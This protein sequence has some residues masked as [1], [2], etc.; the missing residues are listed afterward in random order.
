MGSIEVPKIIGDFYEG[1]FG[2]SILLMLAVESGPLLLQEMLIDLA[3]ADEEV[4]LLKTEGVRLEH[5][6]GFVLRR[7]PHPCAKALRSIQEVENS[8]MWECTGEEWLRLAELIEPFVEGRSGHQYLTS[9]VRDDA[10]VEV[11][12]LEAAHSAD[13]IQY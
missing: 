3:A 11:S 6:D 13:G 2:P 12:Y 10:L 7:A 5:L 9:E 4:D 8:F 1:A